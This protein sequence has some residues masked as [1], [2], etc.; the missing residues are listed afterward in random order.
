MKTSTILAVILGVLALYF[1]VNAEK[2]IFLKKANSLI[3]DIGNSEVIPAGTDIPKLIL[4]AGQNIVP[5]ITD[6]ANVKINLSDITQNIPE[7]I[8]GAINP[9]NLLEIIKRKAAE[10]LNKT[11]EV[12]CP[13]Q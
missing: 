4:K 2:S 7:N 6:I 9:G 8:S 5:K 13:T 3:T 10:I 1:I 12:I 11:N